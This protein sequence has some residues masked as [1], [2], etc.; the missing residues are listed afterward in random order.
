MA[1][2]SSGLYVAAANEAN[3]GNNSYAYE[4]LEYAKYGIA[5]C[6]AFIENASYSAIRPLHEK[7]LNYRYPYCDWHAYLDKV[8]QEL[9]AG[10]G[11]L[12]QQCAQ[13]GKLVGPHIPNIL[14]SL[15]SHKIG[16]SGSA[17]PKPSYALATVGGATVTVT[18]QEVVAT[19]VIGASGTSAIAIL[20]SSGPDGMEGGEKIPEPKGSQAPPKVDTEKD[21]FKPA[22]K[23]NESVVKTEQSISKESLP[24]DERLWTREQREAAAAKKAIGD[25]IRARGKEFEDFLQRKLGGS[26]SFKAKGLT[27]SRE[28]DGSVGNIYYEA[29]SGEYWD[30]LLTS[31]EK[32]RKFKEDMGRGL[33]VALECGASYHLH[34]NS[35]IP[36]IIKEWL[37]KKGIQFTEWL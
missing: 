5:C 8:D 10:K 16:D 19:D 37:T 32:F 7:Y 23:D 27:D 17:C 31:V 33:K 22:T 25:A 28:F 35:Q 3:K 9:I 20:M 26:G 1:I 15:I 34:S 12:Y 2:T 11:K 21:K 29:K 14:I 6:N 36:Q 30:G 18:S 13:A 4:L 24:L